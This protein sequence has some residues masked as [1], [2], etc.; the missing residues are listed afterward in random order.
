M[1]SVHKPT[2]A[3]ASETGAPAIATYANGSTTRNDA[4]RRMVDQYEE[5]SGHFS[6]GPTRAPQRNNDATNPADDCGGKPREHWLQ[7]PKRG[8]VPHAA[9]HDH[10]VTRIALTLNREGLRHP[11]QRLVNH[12]GS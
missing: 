8:V 3:H 5:Q 11:A 6:I 2:L 7:L 10:D 4:D 12:C 9:R 1:R